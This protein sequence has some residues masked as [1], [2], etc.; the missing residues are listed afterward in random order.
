MTS[1]EFQLAV[2]E[3]VR[4]GLVLPYGHFPGDYPGGVFDLSDQRAYNLY[5]WNPPMLLDYDD[6]DPLA[7]LKPTWETLVAN[8]DPAKIRVL[9]R[10]LMRELRSECRRRITIAYGKRSFNDEIALRLRNDATAAQD[11][12]RDRLRS[13]YRQLKVSIESGTKEVVEALDLLAATTWA[14]AAE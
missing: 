10:N 3:L 7:S 2:H 12:E 4:G 13:V 5:L 8:V 6:P 11:V 14:A 9:R 1:E